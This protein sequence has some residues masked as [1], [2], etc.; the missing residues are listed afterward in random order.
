MSLPIFPVLAIDTETTDLPKFGKDNPADRADQPRIVEIACALVAE[1]GSVMDS[2]EH[3]IRPDGWTISEEAMS[4][5]GI[6][7]DRC[8]AEGVPIGDAM[9]AFNALLDRA[10][11]VTAFNV[12]FDL[13]LTRGEL[14]RL[15]LPDRYGEVPDFCTMWGT[16]KLC[17]KL[18]NLALACQTVL[19]IEHTKAQGAHSAAGDR[20]AAIKLYLDLARRGLVEPK[21]RKTDQTEAA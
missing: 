4:I 9:A 3:L 13:K 17:G 18:P 11:V 14:R 20:D 21:V 2:F 8:E 7:L 12:T 1:D 16:R 19:G 10:L 5:H 6:T 15:G